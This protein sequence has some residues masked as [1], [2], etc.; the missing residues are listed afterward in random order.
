V[1]PDIS[2]FLEVDEEIQ[3]RT[4]SLN[5]RPKDISII[6]ENLQDQGV[7]FD[8]DDDVYLTP[9]PFA[10][11]ST[12]PTQITVSQHGFEPLF[13]YQHKTDLVDEESLIG[14]H[15]NSFSTPQSSEVNDCH[16]SIRPQQHT[17]TDNSTEPATAGDTG[18]RRR[19]HTTYNEDELSELVFP[20]QQI[21]DQTTSWSVNKETKVSDDIKDNMFVTLSKKP[22]GKSNQ[23]KYEEPTHGVY[24]Q[25]SGFV[26]SRPLVWAEAL[27]K[28]LD[29]GGLRHQ[30]DYLCKEE[31][32]SEC[33]VKILP[34]D[35]VSKKTLIEIK[36]NTG[37]VFISSQE[38][39][40][41]NFEAWRG[42]V[43]QDNVPQL[44][45]PPATPPSQSLPAPPLPLAE[46]LP[47][48]TPPKPCAQPTPSAA[49]TTELDSAEPIAVQ[50]VPAAAGA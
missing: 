37:V 32:Y 35:S 21:P 33:V 23:L 34:T 24:A 2:G 4:A 10:S 38:W 3:V 30:W 27:E 6:V 29:A 46:Q 11:L 18:I 1:K 44:K 50:S 16:G 47:S 14:L 39:S 26:T 28:W 31:K 22:T 36:L 25:K 19:R 7:M 45:L 17:L 40:S 9:N 5:I 12:P 41:I 49:Q 43:H 8:E 20:S 48:A 13:T 42:I 15:L